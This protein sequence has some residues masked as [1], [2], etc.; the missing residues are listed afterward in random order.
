MNTKQKEGV[1]EV[2]YGGGALFYT[3]TTRRLLHL[4]I[5]M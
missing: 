3:V 4:I 2:E 5:G 1:N